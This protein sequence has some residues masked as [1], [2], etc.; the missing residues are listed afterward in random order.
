MVTAM[1]PV[2]R[3]PFFAVVALLAWSVPACGNDEKS[4]EACNCGEKETTQDRLSIALNAIA[5]STCKVTL[6]CLGPA[7]NIAGL[8][9]DCV[10]RVTTQYA[11]GEFALLASAVDRKRATYDELALS[12]CLDAIEAGGCDLLTKRLSSF[13]DGLI[14]GTV[15]GG[16]DCSIDAECVSGHFCQMASAC[17]G[18]CTPLLSEGEDCADSND[19]RDGLVCSGSTAKCVTPAGAGEACKGATGK[20]CAPETIC[21]GATDTAEGT[22]RDIDSVFSAVE[23]GTCDFGTS[24]LCKDGLECAATAIN[25]GKPVFTC[26]APWKA[27][28]CHVALPE[29]CA[30]DSYCVLSG[31]TVDGECQP[32]PGDGAPC[33]KATTD[34]DAARCRSNAVCVAGTCRTVKALG[35]SCTTNDECY[36]GICKNGGCTPTECGT[37]AT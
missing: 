16:G 24:T 30:V 17:P 6:D 8:R 27:G 18:V 37:S 25:A 1:A 29:E 20:E 34:A 35:G 3:W 10:D 33:G 21:M 4:D 15:K 7:A 14:T 36:S 12:A 5:E 9:N 32:L 2:K 31:A 26:E 19:C 11:Q 13:C 23:G 28:T 22:C